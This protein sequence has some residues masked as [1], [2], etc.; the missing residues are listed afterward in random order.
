MPSLKDDLKVAKNYNPLKDRLLLTN[1]GNMIYQKLNAGNNSLP[2][3]LENKT[4]GLTPLG[5]PYYDSVIFDLDENNSSYEFIN[6]VISANKLINISTTSIPGR[7]SNVLQ[8]VERGGWDIIFNIKLISDFGSNISPDEDD[9]IQER[10]IGKNNTTFNKV[11]QTVT[12][13]LSL[14]DSPLTYKWQTDYQP[15][16]KLK[17]TIVFF[18]KFFDDATYQNIRVTSKYLNNNLGVDKIIPYSISTAQNVDYTNQYDITISCYSD[19]DA[20]G[21]LYNDEIIPIS[22]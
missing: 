10:R 5:T 22:N 4:L 1:A 9:N 6:C 2:N 17:N 21:L 11:I 12:N 20:D 16:T 13:P 15:D 19:I 8:Y 7:N 3:I 18:D 14:L